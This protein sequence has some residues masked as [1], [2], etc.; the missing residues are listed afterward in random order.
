MRTL[1]PALAPPRIL[2]AVMGLL[3]LTSH[4]RAQEVQKKTEAKP[5]AP[6][7]ETIAAG[8]DA[9]DPAPKPESNE[10]SAKE[11][12]RVVKTDAEWRRLLTYDQYLVTR[13]KA[14]EPAF[15]GRYAHGRFKGTF[16]CV[17]CGAKLFDSRH[18][19]DSGTGW[20]SFWRPMAPQALEESLD[21]SEAEPR[22]EVTCTRCGAHLGHVFN[23]GPA[24]TG[25]RYCINSLA[26]KLDSEPTRPETATRKATPRR[27][28]GATRDDRPE[29]SESTAPTGE[30]AGTKAPRR[31]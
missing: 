12:E 26:L 2:L 30:S 20:P 3:I 23:D 13:M 7:G 22:I 4:V 28:S 27:R 18:K 6:A 17:C 25:L 5:E 29:S 16:L 15:S 11:P 8:D 21:R 10:A 9:K 31:P 14:T 19:F 1:L 24:P